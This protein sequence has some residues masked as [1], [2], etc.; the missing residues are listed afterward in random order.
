MVTATRVYAELE[1]MGLVSR[2]QGR[3][4]FVRD[5]AVPAGHGIDQQAVATDA[6]DLSFNYPALPGHADLLRQ[7]LREVAASGDAHTA[8]APSRPGLN[9]CG[10]SPVDAAYSATSRCR[11]RPRL[12][13][14]R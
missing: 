2:E 7:A 5:V 14:P 9:R 11:G 13:A 6:V 1:M 8:G 4:T 3:G 10:P 12:T